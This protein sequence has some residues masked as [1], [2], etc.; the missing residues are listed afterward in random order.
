MAELKKELTN[1]DLKQMFDITKTTI[2]NWR[3]DITDTNGNMISKG[4][5]FFKLAGNGLND[6]VRYRLSDVEQFCK[7]TGKAIINPVYLS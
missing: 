3:R 2:Y 4:L 5:K 7:D 6:P 1:R